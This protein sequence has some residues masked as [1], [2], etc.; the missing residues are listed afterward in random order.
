ML[1][2]LCNQTAENM[3]LASSRT[4][5]T[6]FDGIARHTQEG[7]DFVARAQ[8]MGFRQAVRERDDP[9]GDY[10]SRPKTAAGRKSGRPS[11]H[12]SSVRALICDGAVAQDVRPCALRHAGPGRPCRFLLL[13]CSPARAR[14]RAA[15]VRPDHRPRDLPARDRQQARHRLHGAPDRLD[16]PGRQHPEP[17]LLVALQGPAHA[18]RRARRRGDLEDGHEVHRALR[19]AGHGLPVHRAQGRRG[20]GLPLLAQAHARDAHQPGQG[21][22][23]RQ[24]LQPRRS[25]RGAAHRRRD[26]RAPPRRRGAGPDG[27]GRDREPQA[28]IRSDLR[29]RASCTWTRSATCRCARATGTRP[30][31]R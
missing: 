18:G 29:A 26:L 9:F 23:L 16:R 20:R 28:G 19:Q 21:I 11:P 1:K 22:D 4:L 8:A 12:A 10:G 30:A 2:L 13:P 14:R 17:V 24:R 3:G 25:R 6:L 31:S 7:L 27:L 5:G 15:R